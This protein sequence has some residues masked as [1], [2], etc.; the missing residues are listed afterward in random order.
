MPLSLRHAI[1]FAIGAMICAPVSAWATQPKVDPETCSALRLE[2]IRFRASGVLD[3][4]SKGA[5]WAKAN[6][7]PE[8]LRE[9]E[10]YIQLDE[11][12]KFGCRD[13]KLSPEAERAS[14]AAA[15]IEINSDADP[16]APAANDP[17]KPGASAKPAAA[18]KKK[19]AKPAADK[20]AEKPEKK[21]PP[22]KAKPPPPKAENAAPAKPAKQKVSQERAAPAPPVIV[23]RSAG[24]RASDA[25][26]PPYVPDPSLPQFGFGETV[27]TPHAGD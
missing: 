9:I 8:R 1:G 2:Q 11:Q 26:S 12:V 24:T 17:P 13:A 21:D 16:T 3:D 10:H 22:K 15:R 23:E 27:V 14:E 18:E 4:M 5:Q 19:P 20:A 7:P 6:L 25:Y